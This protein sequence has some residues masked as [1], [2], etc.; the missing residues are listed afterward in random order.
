M[1]ELKEEVEVKQEMKEDGKEEIINHLANNNTTGL[2]SKDEYWNCLR[3][4]LN[5][6]GFKDEKEEKVDLKEDKKQEKVNLQEY[7]NDLVLEHRQKLI[8][9][10][11]STLIE[12]ASEG[13]TSTGIELHNYI[14]DDKE[15]ITSDE[16]KDKYKKMGVIVWREGSNEVKFGW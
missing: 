16:F 12:A 14:Q 3:L 11:T 9:G 5:K 10:I 4:E 1:S 15:F 8:V 6:I 7:L 2:M 13:H